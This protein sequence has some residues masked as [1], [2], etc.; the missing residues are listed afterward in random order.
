MYANREVVQVEE[1]PT[2]PTLEDLENIDASADIT[3]LLRNSAQ[4][5]LTTEQIRE[6]RV[7]FAM[8]MLPHDSPTTRDEIR[9]L[10]AHRYG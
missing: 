10:I 1:H 5:E 8:G 2:M 7:S 6:Q 9:K 3:E 4:K